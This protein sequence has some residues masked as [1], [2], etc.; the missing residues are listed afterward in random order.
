MIKDKTCNIC[1]NRHSCKELC[2]SMN[3]KLRNIKKDNN[4]YSEKTI[5]NYNKS[6]GNIDNLSSIV[7]SY[8][9][10]NIENRDIKRIIIAMLT[11]EQKKI[12]D[13]Y[14]QGYTQREIAKT[15]KVSQSNI[16]QR[17]ESIKSELKKSL[18]EIIPYVVEK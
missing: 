9:L 14:S 18:I 5:N 1:E 11:K 15:L 12:I 2:E 4:I 16:S 7:Y 8:G 6:V 3:Q 10:S 17:I 13:L